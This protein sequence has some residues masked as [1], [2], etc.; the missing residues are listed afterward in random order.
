MKMNINGMETIKFVFSIIVEWM[1]R[2]D[3]AHNTQNIFFD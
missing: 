1:R 3:E 2:V